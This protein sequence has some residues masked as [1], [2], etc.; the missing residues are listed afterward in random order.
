MGEVEKFPTLPS[1]VKNRISTEDLY[2]ENCKTPMN[3]IKDDTNR[4][5]DSLCS[6]VGRINIVKMSILSNAI[7]TFNVIP[8][9]SPMTFFT[10]LGQKNSQ[11]IWKYKRPP[12]AKA[13]LRKKNGVGGINLPD[14]R[15]Y[16]KATVIKI[17]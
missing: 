15:L 17:V 9:R 8:I 6:C 2:M 7:Y 3:E 12:I 16:F 4:W 5:R 13:V 1:G 14:F 10:E 11:F